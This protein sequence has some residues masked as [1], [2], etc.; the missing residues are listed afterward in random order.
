MNHAQRV[1]ELNEV[2]LLLVRECETEGA[3][4]LVEDLKPV[5]KRDQVAHELG[6]TAEAHGLIAEASAPSLVACKQLKAPLNMAS[7]GG[8]LSGLDLYRI[9]Y[10]LSAMKAFRD[11]M[12]PK[13]ASYPLLWVHVEHFSDEK[14]IEQAIL[15]CL[16]SSG[17]VFDAAS[18]ALSLIRTKLKGAQAR[19]HEKIQSYLTSKSRDLLS[20]PIFTV[21]DG[22]YVIPVKAEHRGRIRG[23][24]HDTSST[25]QTI[26]VEPEDVLQA[27]NQ[28]RELQAQEKTEVQRILTAL[29][30]RVGSISEAVA[31]G[32]NQ[33]HIVDLLLA[34]ARL[35][36]TMKASLP[37]VCDG[38]GIK[39][40]SGRHPL[41]LNSELNV[42]PLDIELGFENHGLLITGPNTGG[43]TVAIK[44]VGLFVLMAQMGMYVPALQVKIGPFTQ[45]WADIGDEQSIQQSLSTF[46]GHVKNIATAI[47]Q[48]KKGA[49]L[50]F[51]ELGAG[52]D[53]AEG[54]ALAKAILSHL[55]AEEAKVLASS[56]YGELKAF[57]FETDGFSNAAMEFDPRSLRP[58]Y[59][60]LMGSPGA[61]QA[62]RIAERYG[63]PKPIIEVANANLDSS[64]RDIGQLVEQLEQAQRQARIAQGEADRRLHEMRVAEQKA[65]KKLEEADEVRRNVYAKA[66]D[67]IE[68][69]LRE[70]RNEAH[71]LF[72]ELKNAQD[73][74]SRESIRGRLKDLDSVGREFA[75]EF[76]TPAKREQ[77]AGNPVKG[78]SVRI[79][80]YSQNGIALSDPKDGKIE[81]QI[82][83]LKMHVPLAKVI[84]V[85]EPVI[86]K[87]RKSSKATT[88]GFQKIQ[89]ATREIHLRAK[90]A[91]EAIDELE[92]FLDDSVLAGID[93]VRIVHGKGEGI[94]R[95]VTRDVL[96]RYSEVGSFRDGE[97][98]EGG[99]GV[100][101]AVLK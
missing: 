51:D 14:V 80:G 63:I 81:V 64:E 99:Q 90:R 5:W 68:S 17:E 18:P 83:A 69:A 50:L 41:L 101:I 15:D 47:G 45:V 52:T 59:R 94:L 19:I 37:V 26:F 30:K 35:A 76:K 21:R 22:R 34:K 87:P 92:R 16:D 3:I 25:G 13:K 24:V 75:N 20:D 78:N 1:L 85:S 93:Q 29:S 72:E 7:K 65:Q 39:V 60:L 66:S 74:K 10:A 27:S 73:T 54:A 32:L 71:Q 49:L 42:V 58:T 43:K 33:A 57:A 56:H 9:G 4:A 38:H 96:R 97:A 48:L 44:T 79:E 100:T 62:L 89:T 23:V 95:Q 88:M 91:E 86:A 36:Y 70:I 67:V 46:S 82:G 12:T 31:V 11:F 40:H 53:P 77:S 28:L 98:G 6:R 8:V 84:S 55:A 61:S 2:M